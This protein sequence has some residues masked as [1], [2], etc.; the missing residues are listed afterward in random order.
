M[1]IE[2]LM[3]TV[4]GRSR[5]YR[6]H[7]QVV[8]GIVHRYRC[9]IAWR[10]LP[11]RFGPWQTVWK[12]H[13]RFSRDGTWD[14]GLSSVIAAADAAGQV[15]WAV[16]I[17]ST[18]NRAHQHATTLPRSPAPPAAP[19]AGAPSNDMKQEPRVDGR[20]LIGQLLEPA[21]HGIGRSRGGQSTKVHHA[22][23]GRGRPLAVL[24]GPGQGG[25]PPIALPLL[26][27]IR[28]PR[29]GPGRPRTR[30]AAVL[31]DKA[32]SSRAIRTH[33]RARGITSV[34]PEPRDQQGHRKRRGSAGGRPVTY[35]PEAYKNRNVVERSFNTLKQWR[36]LAIA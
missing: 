7:R 23:D 13:A 20:E 28:V 6:D 25:D 27:Q 29:P 12:R 22:V 2:P 16:S 26:A 8:E 31:G 14:K 19:G 34:I 4:T 15:D 3:L 21:D 36:A 35:D 24:I 32:Y 30:P 33:L 17:D 11:E 9:G 5:P 1:V 18:I 10:D